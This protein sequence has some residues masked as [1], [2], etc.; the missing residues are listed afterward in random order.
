VRI[1]YKLGAE[2]WL[3]CY[4]YWADERA[5]RFWGRAAGRATKVA[6]ITALLLPLSP[7]VYGL[8]Y[9]V[10]YFFTNLCLRASS[11]APPEDGLCV[12]IAH[13]AAAAFT[14][15]WFI[16][17][18]V[19]LSRK[20]FAPEGRKLR[21][22]MAER[23]VRRYERAGHLSP[24]WRYQL[25]ISAEGFTLVIELQEATPG[26]E[27]GG[28]SES[29]VQWSAVSRLEAT[30]RHLFLTVRGQGEVVVPAAAF[31]D[32]GAF[33]AFVEAARRYLRSAT[34]GAGITTAPREG[35]A[36][37]PADQAGAG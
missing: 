18:V 20:A 16:V 21:T 25:S 3:A 6:L 15:G 19:G 22:A 28:R 35:I 12:G 36:G 9:F 1:D 24:S 11:D 34:T 2:D 17:S 5:A 33:R 29:R 8:F 27:F 10:V 30:D 31:P 4:L 37:W 26:V 7:A 32:P 23:R 13:A 14:V